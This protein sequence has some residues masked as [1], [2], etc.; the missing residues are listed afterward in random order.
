MG[1]NISII[2]YIKNGSLSVTTEI[3]NIRGHRNV[4]IIVKQFF[5]NSADF[6][7]LMHEIVHKREQLH[8]K[9]NRKRES[10]LNEELNKLLK[11]EM[12]F[13]IEILNTAKIF[14]KLET[15]TD[16]IKKARDL[17]EE[18]K[19]READGILTE[20]DLSD[21][22]FNLLVRAEYLEQRHKIICF[23]SQD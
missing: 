9:K 4:D 14:S 16:R 3:A 2:Q 13:K 20:T 10:H 21:D 17:F 11:L 18:G 1:T 7:N 12:E 5:A 23:I 8:K 15:N 22:Q 6:Q 19:F